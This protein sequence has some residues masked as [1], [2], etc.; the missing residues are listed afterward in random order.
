MASTILPCIS[1]S[2]PFDMLMG[3]DY[4]SNE[5]DQTSHDLF[6]THKP[7][8]D[9]TDKE[10]PSFSEL[11]EAYF[12]E[13]RYDWEPETSSEISTMDFPGYG[14]CFDE[15]GNFSEEANPGSPDGFPKSDTFLD[16]LQSLDTFS[17]VFASKQASPGAALQSEL[18]THN[19]R[20][21]KKD[22]VSTDMDSDGSVKS[23]T[24]L[25][26]VDS[27]DLDLNCTSTP[28]ATAVADDKDVVFVRS[29]NLTL[30]SHA[31]VQNL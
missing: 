31:S 2:S 5:G 1:H 12:K 28:N 23:N 3:G 26:T 11:V 9:E 17:E 21:T 25:D 20:P 7:T 4:L 8:D 13:Y 29:S 24:V 19:D 27:R 6:F 14:A 10:V 22:V 16:D 15:D 18:V 30:S